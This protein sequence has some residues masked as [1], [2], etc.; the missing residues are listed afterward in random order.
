M[1][2]MSLDDLNAASPA[3]ALAMLDGI[4]EHSPWIAEQALEAR[5]F[6]T[7]AQLEHAMA[8]VARNA[9]REQQL[10][11][12]RAH[13]ELAGKAM[14]VGMLTAESRNEQSSSGL[15]N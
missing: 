3:A 7:L 5:P 15:T 14:V 11:L 6:K 4:Y 12:V 8:S 9:P 1:S 13:P 2:G 10:A